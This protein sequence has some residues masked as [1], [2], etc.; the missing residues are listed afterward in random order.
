ME[1][2]EFVGVCVDDGAGTGV[3]IRSSSLGIFKKVTYQIK[4]RTGLKTYV[5]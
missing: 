5:R 4:R 1:W 3:L 2:A